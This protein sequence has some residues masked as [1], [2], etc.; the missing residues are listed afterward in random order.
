MRTLLCSPLRIRT[1]SQ[2]SAPHRNPRLL[3]SALRR[4]CCCRC[5]C[6]RRCS[7]QQTPTDRWNW[8]CFLWLAR[9]LVSNPSIHPCPLVD[10]SHSRCHSVPFPV[11]SRPAQ[12]TA[13]TELGGSGW[14]VE[15]ARVDSLSGEGRASQQS[16]V[17]LRSASPLSRYHPS[18]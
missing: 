9:S 18:P 14:R 4:W 13:D 10:P 17:R 3:L 8:N 16:A 2:G 11:P 6:R 7:Y 5:R 12:V 1:V 15:V